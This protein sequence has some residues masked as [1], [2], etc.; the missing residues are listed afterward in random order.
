[1]ASPSYTFSEFIDRLLVGLYEIDHHAGDPTRFFDLIDISQKLKE[2]PPE[3]WV[4]D[5]A[6]VLRTMGLATILINSSIV[7][8]QLTGHG[9][10][11]VEQ[12]KGETK[13]IRRNP[14]R[15]FSIN[16]TGNGNQVAVGSATQTMTVERENS[17]AAKLIAEMKAAVRQDPTLQ[18]VDK[19]GAIIDLELVEK[20]IRKPEPNQTILGAVL[21]Q[22]SK[23]GSIAGKIAALIQLING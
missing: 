1:M 10:L 2:P 4:L 5:A 12:D 13:T 8:A 16:V 15:Y 7:G 11:Y 20:E 14:D 17:L 22:L 3:K 21:Q 23:I 19:S 9:R 18:E 6:N